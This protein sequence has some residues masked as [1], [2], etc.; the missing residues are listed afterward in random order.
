LQQPPFLFHQEVPNHG[1]A[2]LYE[3]IPMGKENDKRIYLVKKRFGSMWKLVTING[4]LLKITGTEQA[5]TV[6]KRLEKAENN[7]NLDLGK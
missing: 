7:S 4:S 3:L 2:K 1:G 5:I 6:L